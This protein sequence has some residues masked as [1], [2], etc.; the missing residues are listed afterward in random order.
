[1]LISYL[2]SNQLLICHLTLLYIF[3]EILSPQ[4]EDMYVHDVVSKYKQFLTKIAI[5]LNFWG[6]E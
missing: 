4:Q 2:I 6:W 5:F 1:M 3:F